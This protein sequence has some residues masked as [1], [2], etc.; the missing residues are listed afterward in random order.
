MF[1]PNTSEA[2]IGGIVTGSVRSS[3]GQEIL[4]EVRG[5]AEKI[6]DASRDSISIFP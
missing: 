5:R 2:Q 1:K 4:W 3:L 6:L